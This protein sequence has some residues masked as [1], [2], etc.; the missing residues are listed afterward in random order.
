MTPPQGPL[1]RLSGP[2]SESGRLSIAL[3][4]VLAAVWL[5]GALLAAPHGGWVELAWLLWCAGCG[6]WLYRQCARRAPVQQTEADTGTAPAVA[7]APPSLVQPLPMP[8]CLIDL[9]DGS[10]SELNDAF[11]RLLDDNVIALADR[12]FVD[13]CLTP[14]DKL[15][16]V[17]LLADG[18]G[19]DGLEL[20]LRRRDGAV[21][22]VSAAARPVDP[23]A[24]RQMLLIAHDITAQMQA[25]RS[26]AASEQR[27][28]VLLGALSEAVVLYDAKG[29]LLTSNRT[30]DDCSW[31]EAA[32]PS[33]PDRQTEA[34]LYDEHGAPLAPDM[35]PAIRS[36]GDG[37]PARDVVIGIEDGG[38]QLRW[39]N[40]NTQPL[41]HAGA[42]RPYAVVASY[43]DLTARIRAE[44]ALRASEQRYALALRGMNEGLA[45]WITGSD[46]MYVSPRLS[47]I[48]GYDAGGRRMRV[49]D[50][51]AGIH[52]AD[53]RAWS[54]LVAS[55]LRGRT[56][57]FQQEL[58]M[59]HADGRYR[60]FQLRG[61]AQR[62]AAGRS[63][64]VVGT[65]ADVSVRKRL[66][67]ID[68]AER[69][70]LALIAAAAPLAEVM[71][72]LAVLVAGL[73]NE[74]ARCAVLTF[75]PA[76]GLGVGVADHALPQALR[77][78]LQRL[79]EEP[80]RGTVIDSLR[81]RRT[82]LYEDVLAE[83]ELENCREPLL[84][85][86]LR[87][88]WALPL[89]A[90]DGTVLGCLAILHD[91][92]W[93]PGRA[94]ENTVERL[95]EIAQFA[96]ERA[97]AERQ[98]HELNESLERRVAERTALLE[99]ANGELEA[100]S[101]SVS[102]DLRSPLRAINGFAHLL[103]EQ[104]AAVLDDEGRDMLDRI[105]RGASRMGLLIDDILHFSRVSRVDMLRTDVDLDALVQAV[106]SD[107][108]EQYPA[109]RMAL[110][111]LGHVSG[112]PAM[113]RQVFVNLL[114]NALK[115]S[116]RNTQPLVEV[117][118]ERTAGGPSLCVR[119]N[120]VGF[121]PAYADRLFGVFQRMHGAEEFPGTGVGLAIVK[122]I[123]ER[124]G[125][126]IRAESAPGRGATFRFTLDGLI[127]VD[128]AANAS[129][130]KAAVS[131]QDG[132]RS[133]PRT[134]T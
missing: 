128:Q 15:R 98:V 113:L 82:L 66:E 42:A 131:A 63:A 17:Q 102:H 35:H 76:G 116:S 83:A 114:G 30:S 21:R 46:R 127:T 71:S 45:E 112:D 43:L 54:A 1:S 87:A 10:V 77:A 104:A 36:L 38:G 124:H 4:A 111:P 25:Q 133:V 9:P 52:P 33:Q 48:M 55:H 18:R 88:L 92:P 13:F 121:D 19:A 37:L 130:D 69:E 126:Q 86:G 72:R 59:R 62:D 105:Q 23:D 108:A 32:Q 123:V 125:G 68:I 29:S 99:Q 80:C 93:R 28:R 26:L 95:V 2:P 97:R 78:R 115:F 103:A 64:R 8:A 74:D 58:R 61:V 81:N 132:L 5:P 117:F 57:H 53:R 70:L 31:L 6:A 90:Q 79:P 41:F 122:R 73:I 91:R 16:V 22:W 12:S 85:D 27:F 84:A 47:Q 40:V 60:W 20:P 106:A 120:G 34:R 100:F 134:G 89:V 75:E 51:V 50:F 118:V 119:D 94:D 14:Q 39:L 7:P 101:Y 96:L 49:R 56:D 24:P 3:I 109:S 129:P 110:S 44:R 67:Q 11:A 107:L 65:V